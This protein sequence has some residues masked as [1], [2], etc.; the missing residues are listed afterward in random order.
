M[1]V[2]E[3]PLA[4]MDIDQFRNTL[5]FYSLMDAV[6]SPEWDSRYYSF[7]SQWAVGEEMGSM[8]NGQGDCFFA[9]FTDAGCFLKGFDHESAM[10]PWS[11]AD[12]SIWPGIF[13]S[14]PKEFEDSLKEPAFEM[15]N[16]SFCVWR[17]TNDSGWCQSQLDYPSDEDP[18]GMDY[19]L[20]SI[21]FG[22]NAYCEFAREYYEIEVHTSLVMRIRSGLPLI[23]SVISLLNS[24]TNLASLKEDLAK[25]GWN[26][27]L[28]VEL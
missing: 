10:S 14:V 7:D 3:H 13:D 18:D 15:E 25:I 20:G 1:P 24:E 21:D 28:P 2:S 6:L 22:A 9:H 26:S 27:Y 11:R 23:D 17:L 8:R 16:T 12:S 4:S 19:L 5:K